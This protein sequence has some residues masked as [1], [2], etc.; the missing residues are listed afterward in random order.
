MPV[1]QRG[2]IQTV[3][4][5]DGRLGQFV[6]Q[7]DSDLLAL[8]EAHQGSKIGVRQGRQGIFRAFDQAAEIL[9]NAGRLSGQNGY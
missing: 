6:A 1:H 3:P 5:G 2:D 8:L 4:V 9:L 7:G